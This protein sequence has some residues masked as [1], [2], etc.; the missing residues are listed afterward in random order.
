MLSAQANLNQNA[1]V[2]AV[3][4]QDTGFWTFDQKI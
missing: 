4:Q 3:I 2:P 1:H